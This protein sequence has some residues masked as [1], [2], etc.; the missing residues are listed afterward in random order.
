VRGRSYLGGAPTQCNGDLDVLIGIAQTA[1]DNSNVKTFTV[2]IQGADFD[3]LDQIAM[4]GGTDCTP[5][6]DGTAN[7]A[8]GYACDV[9]GGITLLQAFEAVRELVTELEERIEYRI[10][11]VTRIS[12]CEWGIPEMPDG[13][14]FN[15]DMVNLVFSEPGKEDVAFGRVPDATQCKNWEGAWYYDNLDAPTTIIAC[16]RTCEYI[17]SVEG[18]DVDIL[19]GCE[20]VKMVD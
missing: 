9:S 12:E 15:K 16:E 7:P 14:T 20:V 3:L 5:N 2:C 11:I 17:K 13:E 8:D 4:Q 10:E 18:G 19:F 1:F 6:P